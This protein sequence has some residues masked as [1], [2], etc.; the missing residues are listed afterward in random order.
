[1]VK[2]QGRHGEVAANVHTDF[3]E[4][5][6]DRTRLFALLVD[7]SRRELDLEAF[8]SHK[9]RIILKFVGV[10]SISDAEALAGCEV[11][12]PADERAELEPGTVYVSDLI[13]SVVSVVDKSGATPGSGEPGEAAS[14]REIGW[15]ADVLFGA[16]EAPL[17]IVRGEERQPN[18]KSGKEY[19]IPYAEEYVQ[20]ADLAAK[21]ILMMLPEGMLDLDAPLSSDEKRRQ[22][23]PQDRQE[24]Q[25][26]EG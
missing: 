16:G 21:R 26:E 9:G 25:E 23:Q 3:P 18:Q 15:V 17:L 2:P 13:G 5:F 14:Q 7:G 19:M 4:L 10:D 20:S 24:S 11:Q 12:I 22:Q 6:A 1:V 8:W